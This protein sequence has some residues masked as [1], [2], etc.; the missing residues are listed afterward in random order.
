MKLTPDEFV[1]QAER[2]RIAAA[3]LE[4]CDLSLMQDYV[5]EQQSNLPL[6]S[7]SLDERGRW[8]SNLYDLEQMIAN[9]Y[10]LRRAFV[11]ALSRAAKGEG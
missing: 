3:L 2:L 1:A 5:A 8:V 11:A 10:P 7:G 4:E 6:L 9:A